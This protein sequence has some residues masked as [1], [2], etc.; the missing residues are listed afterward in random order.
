[1][2]FFGLFSL[3]IF[4]LFFCH[5]FTIFELLP[6]QPTPKISQ[7]RRGTRLQLLNLSLGWILLLWQQLP[8]SKPSLHRGLQTHPALPEPFPGAHF[9]GG[10]QGHVCPL[11]LEQAVILHLGSLPAP[12]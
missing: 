11:C 9:F 3:P 1:M 8:G 4:A 5:F 12:S 2:P 6:L 7:S 10:I